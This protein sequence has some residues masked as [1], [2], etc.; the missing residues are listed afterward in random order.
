M[1]FELQSFAFLY[2]LHMIY[3][4]GFFY[5]LNPAECVSVNP[6]KG[7][8]LLPSHRRA[9]LLC[10]MCPHLS[11]LELY[12]QVLFWGGTKV[13]SKDCSLVWKLLSYLTISTVLSVPIDLVSKNR[14][15][16]KIPL[17]LAC[18]KVSMTPL[19]LSLNKRNNIILTL[20]WRDNLLLP[21]LV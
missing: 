15:S 3:V 10:I 18:F 1:L 13:S 6:E 16:V 8:D 5:L 19:I 11:L 17:Y 12:P 4:G 9:S 7:S 14:T 2:F 21:S 20:D